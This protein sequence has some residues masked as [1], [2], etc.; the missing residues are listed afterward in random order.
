MEEACPWPEK[1]GGFQL[2]CTLSPLFKDDSD[3]RQ[4]FDRKLRYRIIHLVVNMKLELRPS[5]GRSRLTNLAED[6]ILLHAP[7]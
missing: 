5:Y 1:N 6:V 4:R 3:R 7:S 2:A